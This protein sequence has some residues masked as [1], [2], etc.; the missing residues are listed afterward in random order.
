MSVQPSDSEPM[1][2]EKVE[3]VSSGATDIILVD[4]QELESMKKMLDEERDKIRDLENKLLYLRADFENYRRRMEMLL[5]EQA[6]AMNERLISEIL[7]IADELEIAL[8]VGEGLKDP[9]QILDGVR[10][11]LGKL[12][13]LLEKNGVRRI[14]STGNEFDPRLHQA[15][16]R[17]PSSD[18]PEGQ[19]V[20]ELRSG[21]M[22]GN[23]VLRPSLVKVSYRPNQSSDAVEVKQHG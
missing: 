16:E 15:V 17:V 19:V 6:L 23:R 13:Q 9:H 10:M 11:T 4:S 12:Y 1:N 14:P 2:K 8:R 22:L 20:E 18:I 3:K 21:F 7:G 5:Q